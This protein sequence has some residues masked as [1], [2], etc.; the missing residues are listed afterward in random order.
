MSY[1]GL[2]KKNDF[3]NRTY[4]KFVSLLVKASPTL[5]SK[6][7][8]KIRTGKNLNLNNPQDFNEKLQWLKL[9]WQHPL[10]VKCGD[11]FVVRDYVKKCGCEEILNELYGVYNEVSEINW[12]ALPQKFVLKTTNSCG[13]NIICDNKNI[14]YK[15]EVFAKLEKWM[16][17]DYGLRNAEIHYSKMI[18]RIICEK[19][20]QPKSGFLPYDYKIYCFNGKPKMAHLITERETDHPKSYCVDI[21]WNKM[22]LEKGE[23]IDKII[24]SKPK[25]FDQMVSYAEKLSKGFPFVRID[26]YDFQD[27][28]ILGEMTF[29]PLAAMATYY[30]EEAL[31]MIGDWIELPEKHI[32]Q[33]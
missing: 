9:N 14:L 28:P 2:L 20:L 33:S 26:F 4:R 8:Y 30:T 19:Y 24:P 6:Y 22:I 17:I 3:I 15:N 18:P 11:K 21:N 29:T 12:E 23:A 25:C 31:N 13:T 5:A 32:E 1:I 16:K 27:K 10:V 7:L